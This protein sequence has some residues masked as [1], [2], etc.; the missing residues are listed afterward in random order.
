MKVFVS[1]SKEPS[2]QIAEELRHTLAAFVPGAVAWMSEHD[3]QPGQ[4]WNAQVADELADS[5]IAI[6]CVTDNN[7]REPWLNFEAGAISTAMGGGFVNPI[8]FGVELADVPGTLTQFQVTRF[9]QRGVFALI[10]AL[11]RLKAQ[12]ESEY[13]LRER[14]DRLWPT[15]SA[16]ISDIIGGGPAKHQVGQP[17]SSS[18]DELS[19]EMLA[20][21]KFMASCPQHL[22]LADVCKGLGMSQIRSQHHLDELILADYVRRIDSYY[23]PTLYAFDTE[24]RRLAVEKGWA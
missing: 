7:S 5:K 18:G 2:K 23:G 1:W 15:F 19:G 9:D 3:M 11:N 16:K 10:R 17:E 22:T 6:I 24:G 8:L 14:Y 20:V 13:D 21:L 12:P 4:R